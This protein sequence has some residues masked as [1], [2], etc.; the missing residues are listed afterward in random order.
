MR[1][2]APAMLDGRIFNFPL[3]TCDAFL[4][5]LIRFLGS[6]RGESVK[7]VVVCLRVHIGNNTNMLT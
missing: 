1:S 6:H 2:A 7:P 5:F 4:K 3:E